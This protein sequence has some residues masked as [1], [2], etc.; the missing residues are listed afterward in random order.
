M[1]EIERRRK[2]EKTRERYF[3]LVYDL[4]ILRKNKNIFLLEKKLEGSKQE[5]HRQKRRD[6]R[7]RTR[8]IPLSFSVRLLSILLSNQGLFIVLH[9][10]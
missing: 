2:K 4:I 3:R 5:R 9:H 8:R 7:I 1:I 10:D 6:K